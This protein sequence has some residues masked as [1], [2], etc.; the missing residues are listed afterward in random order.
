MANT[1]EPKS[2][3]SPSGKILIEQLG[4]LL[5]TLT[6]YWR[7]ISIQ[8]LQLVEKVQRPSQKGV[9]GFSI[10]TPE[11]PSIRKDDDMVQSFMKIK[12]E[13]NLRNAVNFMQ[14]LAVMS[15]ENRKN[16]WKP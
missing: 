14:H 2:S 3:L 16:C 7:A 9:G 4:E 12:G 15:N 5:E 10:K 13:L 6:N 8:A 11:A 1:I